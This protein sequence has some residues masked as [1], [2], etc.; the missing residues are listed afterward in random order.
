MS[1]ILPREDP[2]TSGQ[3]TQL[4]DVHSGDVV[5]KIAAFLVI[6]LVLVC[7][8]WLFNSRTGNPKTKLKL[9]FIKFRSL[10]KKAWTW[11]LFVVLQIVGIVGIIYLTVTND[12]FWNLF[13]H[14]HVFTE[15]VWDFL[16]SKFWTEYHENWFASAFLIGPF[17]LSK[18]MDWIFVSKKISPSRDDWKNN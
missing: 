11:R 9:P 6:G 3:V 5:Y 2:T 13:P 18:A 12:D 10:F 17:L 4:D 14:E 7:F 1:D 8:W 15:D 16:N